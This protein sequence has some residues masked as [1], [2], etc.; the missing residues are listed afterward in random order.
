MDT[1]SA[2][3]CKQVYELVAIG[4][5]TVRDVDYAPG[6]TIK[7]TEVDRRNYLVDTGFAMDVT[8]YQAAEEF[9]DTP[10]VPVKPA[11]KDQDSTASVEAKPRIHRRSRG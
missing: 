3:D 5:C 8:V 9:D 10:V 11:A 1:K 7:T 4:H 2:I 6:A